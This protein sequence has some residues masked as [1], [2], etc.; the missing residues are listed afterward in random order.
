MH[1]IIVLGLAIMDTTCH[2]LKTGLRPKEDQIY[3]QLE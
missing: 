2:T 1:A 3:T